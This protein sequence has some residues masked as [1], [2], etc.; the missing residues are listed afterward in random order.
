M[1]N[2]GRTCSKFQNASRRDCNG[3]FSISQAFAW[4]G[5]TAFAAAEMLKGTGIK[6]VVVTHNTG[7]REPNL[8]TFD[9][10]IKKKIEND[11]LRIFGQGTKVVVEIVAM[12]A[13][14][15]L[16]PFS[17][18]IA[19]AGTGRGA[20]TAAVIKASSNKFFDIKLREHLVKPSDF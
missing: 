9:Q 1:G 5:Y 13:D 15:G 4:R 19:V 11:T 7:N 14:A 2:K 8:Q 16:I 6:L 17:Y 18:V 20:E 10:E 3:A 12:S